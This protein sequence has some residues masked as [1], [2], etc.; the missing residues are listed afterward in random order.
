[1]I[2]NSDITSNCQLGFLHVEKEDGDVTA[3]KRELIPRYKRLIL[4][5]HYKGA[6]FSKKLFPIKVRGLQ[7]QI[8]IDLTSK[9][10]EEINL[11]LIK[12]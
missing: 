4:V 3:I 2:Y 9:K 1:M 12:K 8:I 10:G 11:T 6:E 5:Q 7:K